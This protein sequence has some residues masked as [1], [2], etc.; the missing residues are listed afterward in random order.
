MYLSFL[1]NHGIGHSIPQAP[2]TCDE[3]KKIKKGHFNRLNK[4]PI[5]KLCLERVMRNTP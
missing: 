4:C 1:D 5:N 2:L 3:T